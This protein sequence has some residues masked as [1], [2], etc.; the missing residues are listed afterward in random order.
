MSAATKKT[1]PAAEK[2]RTEC[3]EKALRLAVSPT[4]TFR[5]SAGAFIIKTAS[6]FE[7]FVR[8]EE[9]PNDQ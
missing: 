7:S 2:L 1:G 8:G 5:G 4:I 6:E 9:T 3:L